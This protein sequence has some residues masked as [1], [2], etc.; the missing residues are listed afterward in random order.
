MH[1]QFD[2][3]VSFKTGEQVF[4]GGISNGWDMNYCYTYVKLP[5]NVSRDAFINQFDPFI[6]KHVKDTE[7]PTERYL[8]FL[9]P[10]QSIH[11][12]PEVLSNYTDISNLIDIYH[13]NS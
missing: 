6:A 1:I 13:T 4:P 12:E 2:A 10:L 5:G 7:N 9:Q 8:G 11:L 3:L